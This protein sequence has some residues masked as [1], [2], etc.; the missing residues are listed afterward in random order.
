MQLKYISAY[1]YI[2]IIYMNN[3][4]LYIYIYMCVCSLFYNFIL[5]FY[6]IFLFF[7]KN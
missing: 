2:Y 5:N 4:I 6:I 1:S 3:N 7:I